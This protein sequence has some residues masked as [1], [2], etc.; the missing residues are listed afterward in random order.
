MVPVWCV[1]VCRGQYSAERMN[2]VL[3]GG[4]PLDTLQAWA[5]ELFSAVPGGRGPSPTFHD[6]GFPFEVRREG[7]VRRTGTQGTN[8]VQVAN[9]CNGQHYKLRLPPCHQGPL[10]VQVAC[11]SSPSAAATAAV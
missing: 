4:E 6:A 11:A 5:E 8:C 7:A 2:L 10:Q 9:V 1:C 3:L